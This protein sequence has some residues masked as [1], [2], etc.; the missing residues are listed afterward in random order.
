MA[1]TK[2]ATLA[3]RTL[4]KP[5][6]NTIKQQAKEHET[7]RRWCMNLAQ[8]KHRAEVNLRTNLLG[9]PAK[10]IR[11]LSEARAIDQGADAIAEGFLFSVAALLILG[12]T[13]RSSRSQA[14]RRDVIDDK[15]EDLNNRIEG[16]SEGVKALERRFEEQ[17]E[18]EKGRNEEL[19]RVL[20]R[21][22][23]VGLRGGW[24]EFEDTSLRIPSNSITTPSPQSSSSS[25]DDASRPQKPS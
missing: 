11:P 22:V 12:E 7:F 2:L 6:A 23:D 13:Y 21:I 4:A 9:E 20:N 5:I 8:A 10:N 1:T 16:L 15:I 14:K 3:I 18:L 19:T 24:A 17:W 25:R